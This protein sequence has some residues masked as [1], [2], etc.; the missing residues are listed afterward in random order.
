VLL[1]PEDGLKVLLHQ[2]SGVE[3][4]RSWVCE[5]EKGEDDGGGAES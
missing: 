2:Q 1:L 5:R 4:W 3:E